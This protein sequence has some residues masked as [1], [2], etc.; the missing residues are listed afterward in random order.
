MR[1]STLSLLNTIGGLI[2]K[3]FCFGPSLLT[4]INFSLILVIIFLAKSPSSTL[5]YLLFT[6]SSPWNSPTPLIS[7]TKSQAGKIYYFSLLFRYYPVSR[8]FSCKFCQSMTSKT[9][10]TAVI[11]IGLPPN[12][13]KNYMSFLLKLSAIYWVQI[14]AATGNPLPIAFPIVKIS[15]TTL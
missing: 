4:R 8:A 2:F 11:A 10:L 6:I 7:P 12:V 5:D 13:L 9:A 14:T 15:G 1:V 3:I